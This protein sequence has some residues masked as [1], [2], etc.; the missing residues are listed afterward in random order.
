MQNKHLWKPSKFVLTAGGCKAS[1]DPGEVA[2]G[3]RF[4]V[5]ILAKV[6]ESAIKRH[7]SGVLLDLGC[8]HA[9]LYEMY[10]DYVSDN[11]C[12]DWENT[13]HK[14]PFLDHSFDLNHGIPLPDEMFDTILVT[15]VL[16]HVWNPEL[17]WREMAR[18]LKP[19]GKIILGVPFFYWLHEEPHDYYRFTKYRLQM[20]C[21]Q[22]SLA[23]VSLEP[24]GGAPEIILDIIAKNL[25]FSKTLSACHFFLCNVFA[26]SKIGKKISAATAQTFPLFYCVVAQKLAG[27]PA[28]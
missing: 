15:D 20:F 12:A 11:I 14:S 25:A 8:G 23:V 3:S 26:K 10:K 21:E 17:L 27:L 6:Y 7:A 2:R 1:K 16:E 13:T 5:D 24:H 9:P 4:T 28:N 18:V 19:R 22:N